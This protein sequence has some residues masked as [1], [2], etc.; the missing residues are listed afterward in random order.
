MLTHTHTHTTSRPWT[1]KALLF[2]PHPTNH[3]CPELLQIPFDL[4]AADEGVGTEFWLGLV[5]KGGLLLPGRGGK[6][7]NT[8]DP[9]P[10][11]LTQLGGG[12]PISHPHP[13]R[14]PRLILPPPC[15][16][17]VWTQ[18]ER[19]AMGVES[20]RDEV[21]LLGRGWA[22]PHVSVGAWRGPMMA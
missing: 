9:S 2:T 11:P 15:P 7:M 14:V 6:N 8:E 5:L 22:P 12:G 4:G 20:T 13:Q 3:Q 21:G 1:T 16:S 10:D 18:D 19:V 17:R